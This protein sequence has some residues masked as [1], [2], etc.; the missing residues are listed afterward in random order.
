MKTDGVK[1]IKIFKEPPCWL[2]E[3]GRLRTLVNL[4]YGTYLLVHGLLWCHF[5]SH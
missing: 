1:V 4:S 2:S 5:E 3:V